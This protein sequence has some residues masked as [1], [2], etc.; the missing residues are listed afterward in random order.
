[1]VNTDENLSL[2]AIGEVFAAK[3]LASH[4]YRIIA[5]NYKIKIGEIDIIAEEDGDLV[6]VEIKTRSSTTFGLPAEAVGRVKQNKIIRVAQH[7]IAC[8]DYSDPSC[9]FD[10]VAVLIQKGC[11]PEIEVIKHAFEMH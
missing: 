8:N 10:V 6:F 7:Y 1:M 4:G 2:G 5:C 9:R 3:Y 11:S